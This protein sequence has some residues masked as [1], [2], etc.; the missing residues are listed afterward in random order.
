M[1]V[2]RFQPS[3]VSGISQIA[4]CA[5]LRVV[6]FSVGKT[7]SK[8]S[9]LC[10]FALC[11]RLCNPDRNLPRNMQRCSSCPL[12]HWKWIKV[13]RSSSSS[14]HAARPAR[15]GE[16]H[17]WPCVASFFNAWFSSIQATNQRTKPKTEKKKKK[18][19]KKSFLIFNIKLGL[20]PKN[21]KNSFITNNRKSKG[22]KNH[23]KSLL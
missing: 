5:S 19:R 9:Q 12:S 16:C 7:C 3:S 4:A 10:D 21:N 14:V 23:R 17:F 22:K 6:S 20:P 15:T 13:L 18:R 1:S 8:S 2:E 11:S